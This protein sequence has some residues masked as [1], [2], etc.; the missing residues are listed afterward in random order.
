MQMDRITEAK[1]LLQAVSTA[2]KNRKMDDS[3]TKSFE[4]ASQMLNELESS[5]V[6]SMSQCSPQSS[7]AD[8]LKKGTNIG[9]LSGRNSDIVKRTENWSLTSS[10]VEVSH[11][12]RRLYES[13]D[14]ARR[15]LKVPY[16]KP[17]RC[18]WG[19]NNNGYQRETWGDVHSDPRPSFGSPASHKYDLVPRKPMENDL[20]SPANGKWRARILEDHCAD[21][22][23]WKSKLSESRRMDLDG[24]K[25][26]ATDTDTDQRQGSEISSVV[27]KSVGN[28]MNSGKPLEKKSWADIVEEEENEEQDLFSGR[29]ADFGGQGSDEVFNDENVN[30]NII[31]QHPGNAIL[32]RNPTVRRSLCFNPELTPES[33]YRA[34]SFSGEKKL[35]R[36]N[37]LQVFQDITLHPATP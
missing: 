23:N 29:Y 26:F 19:F 5:S 27:Q 14:P 30:S 2:T 3:F 16:T 20:S 33:A 24:A 6:R 25:D 15:D 31:C 35:T 17:K 37:R 7:P 34:F 11:A 22:S 32:P 1:F 13:P 18:S 10:E 9:N 4:R 36:R 8:E 21:D 12:R 28:N